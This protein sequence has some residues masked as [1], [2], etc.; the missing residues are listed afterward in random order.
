MSTYAIYAIVVPAAYLLGAIPWGYIFP[1]LLRGVDIRHHGSGNTGMANVLRTVGGRIAATV[2]MLDMGKGALVVGLAQLLFRDHSP[3]VETVA[4]M[5]AVV[6]HNWPVFLRFKG[7]RGSASGLGCSFIMAP[8]AA[9]INV[10]VFII[11]VW[12]SRYVSLGSISAATGVPVVF[13]IFAA[14]GMYP[15]TYGCFFLFGGTVIIFQHRG[16]IRRL[17]QGTERKIGESTI[18]EP[19]KTGKGP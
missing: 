12:K 1:K 8:Y 3:A 2:V 13:A 4:A 15:W 17:I 19:T 14:F 11:T 9:L 5:M 6:G 16:N 7:G 10:P 18:S